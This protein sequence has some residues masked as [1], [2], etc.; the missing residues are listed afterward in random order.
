MLFHMYNF[1]CLYLKLKLSDVTLSLVLK[2]DIE[3][4][5]VCVEKITAVVTFIIIVGSSKVVSLVL[6]CTAGL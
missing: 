1:Q 6:M 2:I 4:G 3:E 5:V